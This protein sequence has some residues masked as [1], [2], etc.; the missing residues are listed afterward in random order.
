[1]LSPVAFPE[2]SADDGPLRTPPHNFEAEQALLGA[3]LMNNRALE[4]VSEFLRPDHFADPVHGRIYDACL[5]LTRRRLK[6]SFLCAARVPSRTSDH[7]DSTYSC[8][9]ALIHHMA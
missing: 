8:S 6:N 4:R 5:A 9:A 2:P 1:M 3:I 7:D